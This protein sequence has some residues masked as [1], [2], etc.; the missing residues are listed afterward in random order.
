MDSR[1]TPITLS[2]AGSDSGGG[3]G[4]QADVKTISALGSFAIT[5]I[6]ALTAQ[7]TLGVQ[8]VLAVPMDFVRKQLDSVFDDFDI[9]S[10]KIG[11]VHNAELVRVIAE[12]LKDKNL[13]IIFDPVMVSSSGHRLIDEDTIDAIRT[14]L[15]P[16][17]TL[18]TP[19][20][21][22]AAVLSNRKIETV[23]DMYAAGPLIQKSGVQNI[24]LKG[25]HLQSEVLTNLLFLGN[26]VI[27]YK[28]NRIESMN[29]HGTGCTLSSA[30]ATFVGQ[31]F[32]LKN[33][34]EQGQLYIQKAIVSAI[35]LKVGKGYGPLNHFYD[36]KKLIL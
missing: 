34:V 13:P 28:S 32:G 31:G 1:N 25:G 8:D 24:L 26:E 16:I 4:I 11:M 27:P 5:V 36:P 19:N 29:M 18:I 30:I 12:V 15:L 9:C 35:N 22:E 23:E 21:D 6:T 2:I 20:L 7:N 17:A 3:A 10:V 33:A 14:H